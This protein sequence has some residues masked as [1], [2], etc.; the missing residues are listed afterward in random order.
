[1]KT[2]SKNITPYAPSIVVTQMLTKPA[3]A[4]TSPIIVI[5]VEMHLCPCMTLSRHAAPVWVDGVLI[6]C[7]VEFHSKHANAGL[8]HV[9]K[10]SRF[11]S[12]LLLQCQYAYAQCLLCS[13]C[14]ACM[15]LHANGFAQMHVKCIAGQ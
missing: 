6:I 14:M 4:H 15:S 8:V 11:T 13:A 1:M 9:P 5:Q 3:A 2:A 7:R 10:I 12:T